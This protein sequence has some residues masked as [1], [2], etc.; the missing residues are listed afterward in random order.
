MGKNTSGLNKGTHDKE[1]TEKRVAAIQRNLRVRNLAVAKKAIQGKS[2]GQISKEIEKE[3][4]RALSPNAVRNVLAKDE[5]KEVLEKAYCKLASAVPKVTDNI[6][7]AA[8]AFE[9]GDETQKISWEANKLI[10]QAHGL[11]PTS[12]QSIVHQTYINTQVNNLIPPVIAELA[13]KHFGG[14]I[15]L[16]K[17]IDVIDVEAQAV[18]GGK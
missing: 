13:A 7:G 18:E 2:V 11:L 9:P 15:N 1:N 6:I 5:I 12:Q 16:N 17:R 10:A 8:E 4:G 14:M 3:T